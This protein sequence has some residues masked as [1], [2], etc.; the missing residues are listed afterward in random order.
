MA[1]VDNAAFTDC[2]MLAKMS[3][4]I[5]TANMAWYMRKRNEK[6]MTI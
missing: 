6:N 3:M 5:C 4:S 1:F 2:K